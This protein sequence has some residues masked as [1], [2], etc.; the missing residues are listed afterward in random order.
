MPNP[1]PRAVILSS[2]LAVWSC[3]ESATVAT[4]PPRS[5]L[6]SCLGEYWMLLV[7]PTTLKVGATA[8]VEVAYWTLGEP[9]ECE[10]RVI[11]LRLTPSVSG[12]V[13]ITNGAGP[14]HAVLLGKAPGLALLGAEIT[15][16]DG[17]THKFG[18]T[19]ITVV[20]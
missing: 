18:D 13:S 11:S 6:Q 16:K 2:A 17:S 1:W 5:E 14:R 10:D 9:R 7:G 15:L 4:P 20:E 3:G 19:A 12:V 8:N